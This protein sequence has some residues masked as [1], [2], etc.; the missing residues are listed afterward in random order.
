[1]GRLGTV[2]CS[3]VKSH[4]DNEADWIKY[5]MTA[6][7]LVT[8]ELADHATGVLPVEHRRHS[9]LDGAKVDNA[10]ARTAKLIAERMASIDAHIFNNYMS[11]YSQP[12]EYPEFL[13]R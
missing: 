11:D 12:E 6:E 1:M 5:N 4:V 3:K 7:A 9:T 10:T 13:E 2:T 8:N